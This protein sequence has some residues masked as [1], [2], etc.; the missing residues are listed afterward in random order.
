MITDML[1]IHSEKEKASFHMP[2]HKNGV[3]FL[4]APFD[5]S[6][7]SMDTTELPGTDALIE[8]EDAILEAEQYAARLY[9][10]THSFFL[11]NGSTGGIL[12]MI[13]GAFNPG[14]RVIV[15]K[16][17]HQSVLNGIILSGLFPVYVTPECSTL[18]D[19][20]GTVSPNAIARILAEYPDIK[21]AVITGPNYYGATADIKNIANLL[22]QHSALLLVDEA[23]GAHFPFSN[24]LPE[25]AVAQGADMS[26]TSLHKTLPAPNQTALLNIGKHVSIQKVRAAVRMFQTSSPSYVLLAAME[27][28][29]HFAEEKGEEETKRLV[30][31][32]ASLG[33]PTLDDPLKLMPTWADKGISGYDAEEILRTKFGVY[34]EMCNAHRILCMS[35]WCNS[36]AD[37]QRLAEGINYLNAMPTQGKPLKVAPLKGGVISIPELTPAETLRLTQTLVPLKEAENKICASAVSAFPPCVPILLPGERITTEK[38]NYLFEL[39]NNH[40]TIT[41]LV[42]DSV[43]VLK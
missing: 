15:D 32:L 28:A 19:V 36:E 34:I 42:D 11:V 20:P 1:K 14:D 18:S 25:S 43:L 2:G 31:R 12:A 5:G 8:P 22:H 40:A 21:G 23:H 7:F 9:G 26:V 16:N 38:I 35:S 30:A 41:G 10:A 39:Q 37:I 4:G 6:V 24:M 29:L 3:G 27:Y 17:C 33:C 13:Y